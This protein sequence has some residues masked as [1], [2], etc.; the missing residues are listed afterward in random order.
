MIFADYGPGQ[1]SGV[2]I[3]LFVIMLSLFCLFIA[4]ATFC[5]KERRTAWACF[6]NTGGKIESFC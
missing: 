1:L 4:V 5:A 6:E 2:Y 3:M